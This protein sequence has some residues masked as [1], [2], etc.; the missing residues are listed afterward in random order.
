MQSAVSTHSGPDLSDEDVGGPGRDHAEVVVAHLEV[1]LL[2]DGGHGVAGRAVP[3]AD[4]ALVLL[5]GGAQEAVT[6][7][8]PTLPVNTDSPA[9]VVTGGSVHHLQTHSESL[10]LTWPGPD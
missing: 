9:L 7:H 1:L 4:P 5:S 10:S 8:R 3:P 6:A 2:D